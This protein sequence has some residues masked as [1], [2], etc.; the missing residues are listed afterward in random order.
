ML[1]AAQGA[2]LAQQE[3]VTASAE[4]PRTI[5]LI[6]DGSFQMTAQELATIIR[7]DLNV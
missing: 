4:K 7:H 3:R 6:G 5:L 1:P 2:A